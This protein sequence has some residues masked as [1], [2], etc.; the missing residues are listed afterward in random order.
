MEKY[1]SSTIFENHYAIDNVIQIG[2]KLMILN[3]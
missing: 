3:G 1:T 2:N